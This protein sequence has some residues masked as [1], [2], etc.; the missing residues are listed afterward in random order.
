MISA[1]R[2]GRL[3]G[4]DGVNLLHAKI[5]IDGPLGRRGHQE[6][7]RLDIGRVNGRQ[8]RIVKHLGF[9]EEV[10]LPRVEPLRHAAEE[11]GDR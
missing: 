8:V 5:K 2:P 3:L 6:L 4:R 7:Q 9:F 11:G 1:T 10:V